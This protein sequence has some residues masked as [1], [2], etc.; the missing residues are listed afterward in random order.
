MLK[1]LH[2]VAAGVALLTVLSFWLSTLVAELFLGWPAVVAVKEG[3]VTGLF[4]LIPAMAAAG[5]TGAALARGRGD[6]RGDGPAGAKGTRMKILA[7]NGVLVMIPAALFLKARAVGGDTDALFVLVQ[8]AELAVGA[9]QITLMG[10]NIRD[11]RRLS[12]RLAR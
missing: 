10:M 9:A 4:V 12:A 2:A 7:V 3:I 6:G 8:A 11:G 5:I 1:T